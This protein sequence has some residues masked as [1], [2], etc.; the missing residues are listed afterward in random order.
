MLTIL[1]RKGAVVSRSQRW[2]SNFIDGVAWT[3]D[4]REVWYTACEI[5][6]HTAIQGLSRDGRQRTVHTGMGSIRVLDVAPDGRTLLSSDSTRADIS[7][8]DINA[9]SEQDLT[10]REWSRPTALFDDGGLVAAGPGGRTDKEGKTPAF[11]RWTDGF[12]DPMSPEVQLTDNGNIP[13][14]SPDNKWVLVAGLAT[15]E[16]TISPTGSGQARRLDNG[17]VVEFNGMMSRT[18]WLPD[19]QQIVFVGE[20]LAGRDACSCRVFRA[21]LP[22]RSRRSASSDRWRFRL[23]RTWSPSA[24][25]T[26]TSALWCTTRRREPPLWR[27]RK[28][29]PATRV[30]PGG[31]IWVLDSRTRPARIFRIDSKTGRRGLWREVPYA[32]PAFTEGDSLRVVMSADGTKFVY[33]YQ[34]HLSELYVATGLR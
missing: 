15:T 3:P 32:D 12:P 25:T 28:R 8:V 21:A 2:A 17:T 33:G 6:G 26:Q 9:A 5:V 27:D 13:A 10:Y 31:S 34:K 11:I 23:I 24:P 14:I 30:G 19:G 7:L 1:D 18:R 16:R 22:G 20:T 29:R 4:A